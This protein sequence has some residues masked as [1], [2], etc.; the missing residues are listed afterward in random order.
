MS[1]LTALVPGAVCAAALGRAW[2][3]DLD[4]QVRCIDEGSRAL[5][6]AHCCAPW[7]IAAEDTALRAELGDQAHSGPGS[8]DAQ[9]GWVEAGRDRNPESYASHGRKT[10][11]DFDEDAVGAALVR[12]PGAPPV[13]GLVSGPLTWCSRAGSGAAME[14]A[15]E[16]A[17]DLACAR[18]RHLA[19]RGIERIAVLETCADGPENR[20]ADDLAVEA[21]RP[22]VRS[23]GHLRVEVLL[24][25]TLAVSGAAA[26]PAYERWVGPDRCSDGLAFLP[27]AAFASTALV[28][29]CVDHHGIRLASAETVLTAPLG[30]DADPGV[31]RHA[32]GLLDA[33]RRAG[34]A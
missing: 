10:G 27:S 15:V 32:A 17:S 11:A 2:P 31:V 6:L 3:D 21:H 25:S 30:P 14:D 24:V 33:L 26:R 7:P 29:R 4:G 28:A 8:A 13:V 34:P 1:R 22:I 20:A 12:V 9:T 18:V 5:G 23:A 19:E 16:A